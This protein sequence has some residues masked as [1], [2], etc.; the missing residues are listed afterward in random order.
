MR[1]MI[2]FESVERGMKIWLRAARRTAL[3]A[4]LSLF[5]LVELISPQAWAAAGISVENAWSRATPGGATV[6][7]GFATIKNNS[8]E[9]DR[10]LSATTA[11]AGTTQI[12]QMF[13]ED[14][15]MKMREVTD[16]VPV[17][18]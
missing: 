14:G 5:L 18:A 3:R 17:P 8:S 4:L 9:A 2:E 16:G 12:H 13:T 6:G 1:N 15:V 7:V 10:L 11:V